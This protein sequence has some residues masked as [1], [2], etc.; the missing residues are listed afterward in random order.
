M[1]ACIFKNGYNENKQTQ[2]AENFQDTTGE[3]IQ[4]IQLGI[5]ISKELSNWVWLILTRLPIPKM[6]IIQNLIHQ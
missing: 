4:C 1:G 6:V 3:K 2:V 5:H